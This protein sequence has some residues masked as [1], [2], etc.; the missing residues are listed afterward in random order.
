MALH[1]EHGAI[2]RWFSDLYDAAVRVVQMREQDE[3]ETVQTDS[4]TVKIQDENNDEAWIEAT[5]GV[6][7]RQ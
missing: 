6:E 4:G 2:T 1:G 7:V 3:I 5:E